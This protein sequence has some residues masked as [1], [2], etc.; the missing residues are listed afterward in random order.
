LIT[1][2][3]GVLQMKC[4]F[5]CVQRVGMTRHAALWRLLQLINIAGISIRAFIAFVGDFSLTGLG[6]S[7]GCHLAFVRG[8][9]A[10]ATDPRYTTY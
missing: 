3:V 2:L 10:F 9:S 7:V 1:T 4:L 5:C 6:R 8:I